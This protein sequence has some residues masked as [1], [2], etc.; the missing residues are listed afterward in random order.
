MNFF[1]LCNQQAN[2]RMKHSRGKCT[3]VFNLRTGLA[4]SRLRRLLDGNA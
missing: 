3:F 1:M 2:A 4:T